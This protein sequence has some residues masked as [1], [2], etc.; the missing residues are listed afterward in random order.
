MQGDSPSDPMV[1]PCADDCPVDNR[2]EPFWKQKH[3]ASKLAIG[4]PGGFSGA[5]APD[6]IPN[7]AVKRSS[8][9]DTPSQ[10]AGKSVAARSANRKPNPSLTHQNQPSR[11]ASRNTIRRCPR[12]PSSAC[13]TASVSV[14]RPRPPQDLPR[15]RTTLKRERRAR[16]R[17][18]RPPIPFEPG[19]RT[20]RRLAIGRPVGFRRAAAPEGA[21]APPGASLKDPPIVP[22]PAVLRAGPQE[23]RILSTGSSRS[24]TGGASLSPIRNFRRSAALRP[25]SRQGCAMTVRRGVK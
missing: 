17:D 3:P 19:R 13:R 4:R 5:A 9:H 21:S 22:H 11:P 2:R 7:S 1:R 20:L 10:D 8:A 18:P 15:T 12:T 14:K 24:S 16:A 25:I 23:S 6:P